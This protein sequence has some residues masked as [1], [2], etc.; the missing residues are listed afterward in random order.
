MVAD[1]SS[2]PF[3]QNVELTRKVVEAAHAA[4]V[5]VEGELGYV[6][7]PASRHRQP[8]QGTAQPGGI[9]GTPSPAP[10]RAEA[11]V[12]RTGVDSLAVSIGTVHGAYRGEP[13]LDMERLEAIRCRVPVPLVLHGGSGVPGDLLRE[14]I[15]RGITKI[16]FATELKHAWS[17][18]VRSALAGAAASDP[19]HVS[20]AGLEALKAAAAGKIRLCGARGRA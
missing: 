14:A 19:R 6:P 8:R 7:P 12:A 10:M 18:T 2:R 4:G 13:Q 5:A 1:Y 11:V 16:N 20:R 17:H 15:A 3:A 9:P